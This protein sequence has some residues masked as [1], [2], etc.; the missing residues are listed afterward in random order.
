MQPEEKLVTLRETK[1]SIIDR[2]GKEN[3][4]LKATLDDLIASLK[5]GKQV[6]E[7]D[8]EKL[9]ASDED[10]VTDTVPLSPTADD[11]VVV[12]PGWDNASAKGTLWGAYQTVMFMS[13]HRPVRDYG[14]D[15]RL[16]RALYGSSTRAVDIK[17]KASNMALELVA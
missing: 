13:D 15:I 5:S 4:H 2:Q 6:S 12:N 17:T 14:D 7:K 3:D 8:I 11:S 9:R 16:D 10:V 1:Q